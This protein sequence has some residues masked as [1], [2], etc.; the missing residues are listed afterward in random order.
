MAWGAHRI[1]AVPNHTAVELRLGT[2]VVVSPASPPTPRPIQPPGPPGPSALQSSGGAGRPCRV[3]PHAAQIARRRVVP[4]QRHHAPWRRR[5]TIMPMG[6]LGRQPIPQPLHGAPSRFGRWHRRAARTTQCAG[7][8]ASW[9]HCA[10]RAP[11]LPSGP[12]SPRAGCWLFQ[13]LCQ[14]TQTAAAHPAARNPHAALMGGH[15]GRALSTPRL[16]A[17]AHRPGTCD[18]A[19]PSLDALAFGCEVAGYTAAAPPGFG[20]THD[21]H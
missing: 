12:S 21:P 2:S 10:D 6:Q 14:N 15:P 3:G 4:A 19:K 7:W 8:R 18:F 17:R 5:D 13:H 9:R 20:R 1:R 11:E 16:T